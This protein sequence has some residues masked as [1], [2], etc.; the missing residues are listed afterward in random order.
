MLGGVADGPE[1]VDQ[2]RGGAS[3]RTL[4]WAGYRLLPIGCW[5]IGPCY[6]VV[7]DLARIVEPLRAACRARP[8]EGIA[9]SA[10]RRSLRLSRCEP[11]RIDDVVG[12]AIGANRGGRGLSVIMP[13]HVQ[14]ARAMHPSW[15]ISSPP[16]RQPRDRR[17][18][19][20]PL[21]GRRLGTGARELLP[22]PQDREGRDVRAPDYVK[23][24]RLW[25][26]G[27]SRFTVR[28]RD[29]RFVRKRRN[30]LQNYLSQLVR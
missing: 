18:D 7:E 2:G 29:V 15:P 22:G 14:T 28:P 25:R 5:R 6:W 13:G 3:S 4:P 12:L 17:A 11:H 8:A 10:A 30:R 19:R 27:V 9:A 26:I 16:P 24:D 1:A 20:A 23:A 21:P